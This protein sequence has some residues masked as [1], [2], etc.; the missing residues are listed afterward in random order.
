IFAKSLSS[1]DAAGGRPAR[2]GALREEAFRGFGIFCRE[3]GKG[4]ATFLLPARREQ[5][6][7]ELE[8]AIGGAGR[9]GIFLDHLGEGARRTVIV[10][11]HIGDVADPVDGL[12]RQF[13]LRIGVGEAAEGGAGLVI[14]GPG[15]QVHRSGELRVDGIVGGRGRR[16]A[17]RQR[18]EHAGRRRELGLA[19]GPRSGRRCRRYLRQAGGRTGTRAWH[20][21]GIALPRR[22]AE[23]LRSQRAEA[24]FEV[25]LLAVDLFAQL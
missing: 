15:E 8:H 20:G 4:S 18:A 25:L 1:L 3:R 13:I 10:L 17:R 7:A 16:R 12:R 24:V 22:A 23:L 14:A 19:A 9:G 6:L 5:R 11:L 2:L 21:V